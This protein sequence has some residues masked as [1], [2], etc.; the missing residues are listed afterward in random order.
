MKTGSSGYNFFTQLSDDFLGE[1]PRG[2]M[3]ERVVGIF[4]VIGT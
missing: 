4:K 1:I 3:F 2:E